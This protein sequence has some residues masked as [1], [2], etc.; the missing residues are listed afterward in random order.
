[1][2]VTAETFV[3]VECDEAPPADKLAFD[4]DPEHGLGVCLACDE[5]LQQAEEL[6]AWLSREVA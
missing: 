6:P 1:M 5:V 2:Q 3:C 4:T